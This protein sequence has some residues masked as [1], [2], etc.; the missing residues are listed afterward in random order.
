MAKRA[1]MML[2]CQVL[3]HQAPAVCQSRSRLCRRR[4]S[5]LC[6]N[7]LRLQQRALQL[8]KMHTIGGLSGSPL[9]QTAHGKLD[10]LSML[11]HHYLVAKNLSGMPRCQAPRC[12]PD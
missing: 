5:H 4:Y 12:I 2:A 10:A 3:Q 9:R 8:K 1:T 6:R 7:L 11:V